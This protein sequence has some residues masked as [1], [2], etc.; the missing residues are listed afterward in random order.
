MKKHVAITIAVLLLGGVIAHFHVAAQSYYPVVRVAAGNFSYTAVLDAV[1][2]RKGCG[3]ASARFLMP[4]KTGC[5]QCEVVFARCARDLDEFILPTYSVVQVPGVR[6]SIEASRD[7]AKQ[8]CELMA[9]NVTR[10]GVQGARC[11]ASLPE[12]QGLA[13][14]AR[15]I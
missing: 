10:L 3:E 9:S 6:I 5:P 13:S 1:H 8:A 11:T 4:V 14:P 7:V 12:T 15:K 2:E